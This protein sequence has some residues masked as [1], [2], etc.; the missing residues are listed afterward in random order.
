MGLLPAKTARIESG[1]IQFYKN[2]K[3]IIDLLKLSPK[4]HRKL[5]G[6]NLAMIF[7]DPMTSLNPVKRCGNQ[8]IESLLLHKKISEKQAKKTALELF[9]EMELENPKKIYKSYPHQLSG[10][11]KQRVMIA[12]ALSCNPKILIADE[13]TTALDVTVQQSVLALLKRL[14]KKFK[15]SII[16]ITHDL[17]VLAQIA[18]N[19]IIMYEGKIV[20]TGDVNHIFHHAEHPYTK[21]LIACRPHPEKRLRKLPSVKDFINY[22][23]DNIVFQSENIISTEERKEK[24]KQIYE[25]QAILEIK[26]LR[27]QYYSKKYFYSKKEVFYAVK[28]FS[29]SLYPGESLG[30]VGE[31]GCGKTTLSR[32]L[33]RLIDIDAGNIIY[34]GKDLSSLSP[35]QMRPYRKKLQIVF[36]DPY[37]SLNE[38]IRIGDAIKEV[39]VVHRKDLSAKEQRRKTEEMLEKVNLDKA[40]YSRYPHELSG[41][42][43]QRVCIAR[44]LVLEPE[45]LICDE[46]VSALDVSVQAQ[47]LNLL[48]ELKETFQLSYLFISHDLSVVKF[49]ADRILIMQKGEIV[50]EGNPDEIYA[51]PQKAYTKKLIEAIPS[52]G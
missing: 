45:I 38:R 20:E 27:K 22:N 2:D 16:F 3:E 48:N 52:F 14:Q 30:L 19:L 21:G 4:A 1:S 28:D 43:R 40:F 33:L 12:I 49:M 18:D 37:S 36:Q 35:Q 6:E 41:G 51:N 34:R 39:L 26:N 25:Q 24:H 11:Q 15:M 7:Q 23:P 47:V 44:A 50:E 32:A 13:P 42:Q 10:G 46:S 9:A 17:G 8:L 31:S 5:L 29:F